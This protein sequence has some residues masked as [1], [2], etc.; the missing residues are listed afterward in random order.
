L[1]KRLSW[2]SRPLGPR[3]WE[4][5]KNAALPIASRMLSA[6]AVFRVRSR[7]R[8]HAWLMTSPT[9]VMLLL[10]HQ[11]RPGIRTHLGP[12]QVGAA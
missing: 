4:R 10:L 6:C 2:P 11:W 5:D 8:Q 7:S 9:L 12:R 3:E 1:L